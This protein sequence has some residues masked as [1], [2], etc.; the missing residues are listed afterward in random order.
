MRGTRQYDSSTRQV[1]GSKSS[2]TG[3]PFT[4]RHRQ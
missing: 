2:P 3:I 4:V 1:F